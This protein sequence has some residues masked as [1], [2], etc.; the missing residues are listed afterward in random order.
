MS[1]TAKTEPLDGLP[2][3]KASLDLAAGA[4]SPADW[5]ETLRADG[6]RAFRAHGLPGR[7]TEHWKYTSVA[8][9][10]DQPF[11]PAPEMSLD[12]LPT[13][14]ALEVDAHRIVLVNGR[15]HDGLSDDGAP[16][17][18]E[19][20]SLADVL[21][22]DAAS[23]KGRLGGVARLDGHPFAALNTAVLAVCAR[24]VYLDSCKSTGVLAF[25]VTSS[26]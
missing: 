15:P 6:L 26:Q 3:V 12:S 5:L 22:D 13:A 24:L 16:K 4:P 8:A 10:K 7:R 19:I 25:R 2:F 14:K 9:V 21:R 20:L 18:V 1:D 17:G 11:A 23:L